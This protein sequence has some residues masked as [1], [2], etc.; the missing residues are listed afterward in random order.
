MPAKSKLDKYIEKIHK[1]TNLKDPVEHYQITLRKNDSKYLEH[2]SEI[3]GKMCWTSPN[4]SLNLAKENNNKYPFYF[5]TTNTEE[6]KQ[7]YKY[8]KK[9]HIGNK[10]PFFGL[11]FTKKR[12]LENF[13]RDS[14]K[15]PAVI[16]LA[17]WMHESSFNNTY[18]IYIQ[19]CR[20]FDR[21]EVKE[22]LAN[23]CVKPE[24]YEKYGVIT[25]VEEILLPQNISSIK[26]DEDKYLYRGNLATAVSFENIYNDFINNNKLYDIVSELELLGG[27]IKPKTYE[28]YISEMT[29]DNICN[30]IEKYNIEYG[31]YIDFNSQTDLSTLLLVSMIE[32]IGKCAEV[33]DKNPNSIVLT[34]PFYINNIGY[35][36]TTTKTNKN[37]I[38]HKVWY[39]FII[40][41]LKNILKA[42]I[43][44]KL[45]EVTIPKQ[46]FDAIYVEGPNT[47]HTDK[48]YHETEL[49]D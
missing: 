7:L 42:E 37:Y 33:V 43:D 22:M 11:R 29:L 12:F 5:T 39:N 26:D 17:V 15:N 3:V 41:N 18:I 31:Y 16:A 25:L 27:K 46:V 45:P 4:Y 10:S 40:P 9:V 35:Y 48:N 6:Y 19:N 38:A 24:N 30:A 14:I 2:I 34:I 20:I 1:V 44:D 47:S 32:I 28:E 36:L 21:E 13:I 49:V 23:I 8:N